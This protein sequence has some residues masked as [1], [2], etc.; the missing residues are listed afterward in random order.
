MFFVLHSTSRNLSEAYSHFEAQ[1]FPTRGLCDRLA[2][3]GF[4]SAQCPRVS[5]RCCQ[6]ASSHR[7]CP[8]GITWS[9]AAGL[10]RRET[11]ISFHNRLSGPTHLKLGEIPRIS[12]LET[13]RPDRCTFPA[14]PSLSI[15]PCI[16]HMCVFSKR[17]SSAI[18][19]ELYGNGRTKLSCGILHRAH[20]S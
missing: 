12:C 1:R 10:P 6:T 7:S 11:E 20:S 3:V 17:L 8:S 13:S 15:K 5:H 9:S 16:F 14:C 4:P 18:P 19:Q 2:Q